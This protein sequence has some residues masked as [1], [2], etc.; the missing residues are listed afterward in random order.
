[1]LRTLLI[2]LIVTGWF[3]QLRK[4]AIGRIGQHTFRH[5]IQWPLNKNLRSQIV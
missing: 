4:W 3:S 2:K 1:M 5:N